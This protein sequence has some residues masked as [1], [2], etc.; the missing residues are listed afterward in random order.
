MFSIDHFIWIGISL[1]FVGILL[2]FSLKYKFSFKTATY[3]LLGVYI[4]SE[5]AKIIFQFHIINGRLTFIFKPAYLP[6]QIC[7]ITLFFVIYLA[8][9]KNQKGIEFVKSFVVEIMLI[10]APMALIFSTVFDP[11]H[12]E[13]IFASFKYPQVYRF[14]IYHFVMIWYGLYLVITKQVKMGFKQWW[15]SYLVLLFLLLNSLWINPLFGSDNPNFMFTSAPP[16]KGIP[17]INLKHGYLVFLIHYFI[18]IAIGTFLLQLPW[19]I[20]QNSKKKC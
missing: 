11:E 7:T 6:L 17:L 2:F 9:S 10:A 1:I 13:Y 16:A 5:I 19:I 3:I 12:T 14:F 20:K 18:V 8:F 4:A 15:Q